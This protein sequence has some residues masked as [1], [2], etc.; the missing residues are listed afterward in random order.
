MAEK[1]N[2]TRASEEFYLDENGKRQDR[3]FWD[4]MLGTTANPEVP[5]IDHTADFE[6]FCKARELPA[7]I[8]KP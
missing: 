5:D 3:A 4:D 8:V 2:V 1:H 7:D 6:A